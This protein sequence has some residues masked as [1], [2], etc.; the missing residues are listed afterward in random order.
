MAEGRTPALFEPMHSVGLSQILPIVT[1]QICT[2][3]MQIDS[4]CEGCLFPRTAEV[5][6]PRLSRKYSTS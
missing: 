2:V 3:R 1:V 4:E 5:L 6:S